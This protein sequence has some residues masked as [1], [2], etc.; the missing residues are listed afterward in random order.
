MLRAKKVFELTFHNASLL[1]RF[2]YRAIDRVH[3]ILGVSRASQIKK[4]SNNM[5][6]L[7]RLIIW[8]FH[9]IGILS[10]LVAC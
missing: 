7:Y 9:N 10:L 1:E 3:A 8:N 4:C 5:L 2:R 6:L